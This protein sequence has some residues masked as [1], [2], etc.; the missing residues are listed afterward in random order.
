[1]NK[2]S[3]LNVFPNISAN[4]YPFLFSFLFRIYPKILGKKGMVGIIYSEVL[5][6]HLG[7]FQ[8]PSGMSVS[9]GFKQ[10]VW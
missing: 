2:K 6:L 3:M 4:I 5:T 10:W 7:H 1:M 9:G 8:S